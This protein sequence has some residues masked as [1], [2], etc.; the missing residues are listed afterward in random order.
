MP[1][2]TTR[3]RWTKRKWEGAAAQ[4]AHHRPRQPAGLQ[5][6]TPPPGNVRLDASLPAASPSRS[7]RRLPANPLLNVLGE[8]EQADLDGT[9]GAA[10]SVN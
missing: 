4:T 9:T 1:G 3:E 6:W 8:E 2:A 5:D 10:E 7:K